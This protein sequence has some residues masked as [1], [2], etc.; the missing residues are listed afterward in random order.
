LAGEL[1]LLV[2]L[3]V[4]LFVFFGESVLVLVDEV[5][6]DLQPITQAISKTKTNAL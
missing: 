5:E 6:V 3:L 1:S 4:E 2:V